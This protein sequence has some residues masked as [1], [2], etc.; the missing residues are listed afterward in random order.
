LLSKSDFAGKKVTYFV[1]EQL[2]KK[3]HF[4]VKKKDF[5]PLQKRYLTHWFDEKKDGP[6]EVE[7]YFFFLSQQ[8]NFPFITKQNGTHRSLLGFTWALF[9]TKK[10]HSCLHQKF[11][12]S[13]GLAG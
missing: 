11:F 2:N 3:M 6:N 8:Q 5:F 10:K 12:S 4:D 9:A 13:D 7:R 1:G